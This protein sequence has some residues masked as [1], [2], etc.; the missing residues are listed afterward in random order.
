MDC[1]TVHVNDATYAYY[2]FPNPGKPKMLMLHGMMV[3]SH[4]FNGVAKQLV[5]DFHLVLLDLKGHGKSSDG[6][7]YDTSYTND[8]ICA[9]LKAVHE[10]VIGEP[11]HLVGYSLG[12]QYALRFAG[13]HP[14]AL[15]SVVIIDSVPD[16][17]FKGILAILWAMIKTPKS[18]KNQEHVLRF[19]D[20]RIPG[21]GNYMLKYCMRELGGGRYAIRYD[22]K[23]LAP[24]TV[25][26]AK[27]RVADLWAACKR[28]A[29]PV[30]VLRAENSYILND[31]L[32]QKFKNSN[33]RIEVVLMRGLEHNL[34]FTHPQLVAD[35]IRSFAQKNA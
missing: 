34:V 10:K 11:C 30:R 6:R 28:I 27:Q 17:S 12:G 24:A 8:A 35:Q 23:N 16:V 3:E 31:K 19:Y 2:E 9:D 26:K 13:S 21:L 20:A 15:K 14:E 32:E 7:S 18:F 25:A 29:T 33:P 5:E 4:C 22:K 1:Q